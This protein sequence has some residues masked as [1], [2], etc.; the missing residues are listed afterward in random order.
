[1][2]QH[3]DCQTRNEFIMVFI[4]FEY[5]LND[6]RWTDQ[7]PITCLNCGYKSHQSKSQSN[8]GNVNR[9]HLSWSK[10]IFQIVELVSS[11]L[12]LFNKDYANNA[13]VN[14]WTCIQFFFTIKQSYWYVCASTNEW[15]WKR[16]PVNFGT[17]DFCSWMQAMSVPLIEWTGC[18]SDARCKTAFESLFAF[19]TP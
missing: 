15:R 19:K 14:K 2:G 17:D 16:N 4:Q 1:M 10:K 12:T 3:L 5:I 8:D 11:H 6:I 9:I 13:L 18:M 7:Y